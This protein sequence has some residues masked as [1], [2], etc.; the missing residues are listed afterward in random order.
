MTDVARPVRG[1]RIGVRLVVGLVVVVRVVE[2]VVVVVVVVPSTTREGEARC[3]GLSA[4]PR[5]CWRPYRLFSRT[6]VFL[7]LHFVLLLVDELSEGVGALLDLVAAADEVVEEL[8]EA[9]GAAV[10]TLEARADVDGACGR[11]VGQGEDRLRLAAAAV[12]PAVGDFVDV[13]LRVAR[14]VEALGE[15]LLILLEVDALQDA[16]GLREVAGG[17]GHLQGQG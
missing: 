3:V 4:L 6:L 7:L 13:G 17:D 9:R 16:R 5:R 8:R 11:L 10:V 14:E 2:G 15:V 12:L 1:G